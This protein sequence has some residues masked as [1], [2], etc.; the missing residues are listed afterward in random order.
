MKI[1]FLIII[2]LITVLQE[3]TLPSGSTGVLAQ[4]ELIRNLFLLHYYSQP[5]ICTQCPEISLVFS[6]HYM[7]TLPCSF[8]IIPSPSY[9]HT[10][11]KFHYYSQPI[12]SSHYPEVSL[13]F[14][15]HYLL[16]LL[17]SFICILNP[18]YAH[19]AL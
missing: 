14:L 3:V 5:I 8:I 18:S 2:I 6:A 16:T 7:L 11:M 12:I 10:A 19:T 15:A 9:T 13:L 17:Y 1:K 4:E